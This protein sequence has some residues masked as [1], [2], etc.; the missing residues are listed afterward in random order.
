[1]AEEGGD[2]LPSEAPTC[3]GGRTALV[4]FV[5]DGSV[6]SGDRNCR[7]FIRSPSRGFR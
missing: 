1:M 2:G 4:A 7:V 5:G 3:G 6:G